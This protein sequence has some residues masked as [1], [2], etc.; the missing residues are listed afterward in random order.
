MRPS[1]DL[2]ALSL[3]SL[4]QVWDYFTGNIKES[5]Q[6][7]IWKQRGANLILGE[8]EIFTVWKKVERELNWKP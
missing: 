8:I 6:S 1:S 3:L 4:N 5:H 2:C 7:G